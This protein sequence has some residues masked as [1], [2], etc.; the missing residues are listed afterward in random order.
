VIIIDYE[1]IVKYNPRKIKEAFVV[2]EFDALSIYAV[3][4][5]LIII[6]ILI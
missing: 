1:V 6:G 4:I 5:F 3:G 2:N